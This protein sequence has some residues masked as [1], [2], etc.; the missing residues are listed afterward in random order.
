MVMQ[1]SP[2]LQES[3][4]SVRRRRI[5]PLDLLALWRQR[6]QLARLDA[7]MLSDIGVTRDEAVREADRAIWDA[8]DHWR[9]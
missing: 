6:R 8:P 7:R 1:T 5:G 9:L 2:T 4:P 3:G